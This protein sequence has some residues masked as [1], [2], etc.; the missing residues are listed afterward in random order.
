MTGHAAVLPPI[1]VT[2]PPSLLVE[3]PLADV[4]PPSPELP[5]SP[6]PPTMATHVLLVD[7]TVVVFVGHA[8][9]HVV[10]EEEVVCALAHALQAVA[11]APVH[12][13]EASQFALQ[14]WHNL[15]TLN[16]PDGQ[17]VT[18]VE[19]SSAVLHALQRS[20]PGP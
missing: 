12:P 7:E 16:L 19:P 20:A 4:P 13:F 6:L 5:P 17:D 2:A 15:Y 1:T 11:S 18:H 8:A 14:Y 3:S 10:P 9:R